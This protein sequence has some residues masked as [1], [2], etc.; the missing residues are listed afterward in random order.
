M[1]ATTL[2]ILC[3]DSHYKFFSEHHYIDYQVVMFTTKVASDC[4]YLKVMSI[5]ADQSISLII[6]TVCVIYTNHFIIL[7]LFKW[8]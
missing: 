2:T 7:M 1:S 4:H 5:V 6:F 8:K 3:S